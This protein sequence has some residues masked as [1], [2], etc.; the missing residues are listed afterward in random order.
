MVDSRKIQIQNVNK[1][2]IWKNKPYLKFIDVQYAQNIIHQL[3][4]YNMN[5][6]YNFLT[7]ETVRRYFNHQIYKRISLWDSVILFFFSHP[8]AFCHY[9]LTSLEFNIN[10][11]RAYVVVNKRLL[12]PHLIVLR[13]NHFI[14][15]ISDLVFLSCFFF[16]S[17]PL[18]SFLFS[19]LF[20][21]NN[22]VTH[23]CR[24]AFLWTYFCFSG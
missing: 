23:I 8:L 4:M 16:S 24:N 3:E 2:C 21:T 11:I 1:Y 19:V 6:M 10:Q 14:A 9:S 7:T 5:N 17:P 22:N 13:F 20:L 18:S 15:C 12:S